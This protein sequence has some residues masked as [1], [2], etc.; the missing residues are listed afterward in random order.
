M[1]DKITSNES[2]ASLLPWLTLGTLLALGFIIAAFILGQSA[3]QVATSRESITVKGTAERAVKADKALWSIRVTAYASSVA[4]A[5][6]QLQQQVSQVKSQLLASKMLTPAQ[7]QQYD[8]TTEPV[9]QRTEGYESQIVGYTLSQRLGA[10]LTDVTVP[11]KLN[12]L[13]NQMIIKGLNV[14]RNETQYL[15]SN[16]EDIKLSLIAAATKNAHDRALE[17]AKSGDVKVGTMRS[18]SQG[19]FQINA[20]L[21][22]G[23]DEYGGEYNTSTI[24]KVARVV[25]TVNYGIQ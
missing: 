13:L 6:P 7:L 9:Y 4:D 18:A 12:N 8:W 25:V 1:H 19:V 3:K 24:D 22:T 17:F 11:E 5:L 10:V 16:I 15:V 14:E 20:P 2:N 21:S 23:S